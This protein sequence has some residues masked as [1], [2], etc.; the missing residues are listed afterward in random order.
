MAAS[1][2]LTYAYLAVAARS[3]PAAEYAIFGAFWS[4]ALVVGMGAFTPLEHEV[5]RLTHLRPRGAALPPGTLRAMVILTV[6]VLVVLTVGA[7][8]VLPSLGGNTTVLVLL[9]VAGAVS[10]PQFLVR[11][12]LLGRGALRLHGA[13]LLLDA[14]LRLAAAAAVAGWIGADGAEDYA[15]TLV[16]AIVLAHL[17]VLAWLVRGRAADPS[18]PT[19]HPRPGIRPRALGHLLVGSLC[20]QVLLNAAPV[21][22]TATAGAGELGLAAAFVASFTLVRLP[23]FV[24]VPL[25]GALIPALTA[26][27]GNRPAVRRMVTRTA[28]ATAVLAV[29]GALVGW[30]AGPPLVGLL[31]GERYALPGADL[32]LLAAGSGLYLGLLVTGQALL[33]AARHRDVA[34]VWTVGLVAAVA[35]FAA[36]PG[37]VL[38]AGL[39][40][41]VGSG[42]A[43]ACG[44]LLLLREPSVTRVPPAVP[45]APRED[46]P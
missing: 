19:A 15:W 16:A 1:G 36:V 9:V 20:A 3:L 44:L 37:L 43:L 42:L 22:V 30:L 10:G 27:A 18:P 31:F 26:A 29:A 6:L 7:P 23:L 4:L 14:G 12:L 45:A 40:F 34:L 24:A 38:R 33:A 25:Q 46:R 2:L 41:T 21:L 8:V 5:A 28:A 39:S 13:T 32:A 17:P 35:V 11:G